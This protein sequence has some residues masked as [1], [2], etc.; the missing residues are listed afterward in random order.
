MVVVEDWWLF[1]DYKSHEVEVEVE[2]EV[3]MLH[4]LY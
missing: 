2:V 1:V 4:G 3:E